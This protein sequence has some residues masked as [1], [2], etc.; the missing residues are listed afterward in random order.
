MFT[1]KR[2]SV[3][4]PSCVID[5]WAGGH[6]RTEKSL[7]CLLADNLLNKNVTLFNWLNQTKPAHL[8]SSWAHTLTNLNLHLKELSFSTSRLSAA[9]LW[10]KSRFSTSAAWRRSVNSI[11]WFCSST[12]V[13]CDT[14]DCKTRYGAGPAAERVSSPSSLAAIQ[15]RAWAQVRLHLK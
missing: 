10:R 4:P 2:D 5:R 13:S 8:P 9:S 15:G 14:A 11:K 1:N 6:S 3:K 12:K 7:C